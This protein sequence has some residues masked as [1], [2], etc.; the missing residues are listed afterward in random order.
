MTRHISNIQIDMIDKLRV[1]GFGV[2]LFG[3][4]G[5]SG[6]H[7]GDLGR[8]RWWGGQVVSL[9]YESVLIGGPGQSDLL[10]F[11]GDEVRS[12]LVGVARLVS[13]DFLC[14]GLIAGSTIGT[15][16]AVRSNIWVRYH[17]KQILIHS[18][19][20]PSMDTDLHLLLPSS[21][22]TSEDDTMVMRGWEG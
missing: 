21:L 10:S 20:N 17:S 6:Q 22:R 19:S 13:D 12:S 14:V 9:G 15:G 2:L 1:G 16:V 5:Q 18:G 8:D 3:Q 7:G 4:L 11:G